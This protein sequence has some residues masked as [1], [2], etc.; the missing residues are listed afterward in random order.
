MSRFLMS[1]PILVTCRNK[2]CSTFSYMICCC[3]QTSGYMNSPATAMRDPIFYRWHTYIDEL[4]QAN[5]NYY[6]A[7]VA[8]DAPPV[9][10][11]PGDVI[12]DSNRTPPTDFNE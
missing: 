2:T 5:N 7:E 11:N 9:T 3:I 12:I 1:N 10:I 6:R 8:E 4:W